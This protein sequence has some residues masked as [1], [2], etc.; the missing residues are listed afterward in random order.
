MKSLSEIHS[1]P[2][3]L[4]DI[5][6]TQFG[7][8]SAEALFEHAIRNPV[9][10]CRAL[11]VSQAELEQLQTTL[12]GHLSTAFVARCRQPIKKHARGVIVD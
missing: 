6:E 9:G 11:K 7:I 1:I 3:E 2:S 10:I 8:T 4:R 5:L 12:E